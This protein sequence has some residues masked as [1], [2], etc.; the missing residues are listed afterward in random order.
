ME[1]HGHF[2]DPLY[3]AWGEKG[4]QD[5]INRDVENLK[6]TL[7]DRRKE[8]FFGEGIELSP[9]EFAGPKQKQKKKVSETRLKQLSEHTELREK[10][11][12]AIA[13]QLLTDS[14]E[15]EDVDGSDVTEDLLR[16]KLGLP[17]EGS[18]EKIDEW[19]NNE[20]EHFQDDVDVELDNL[21]D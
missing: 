5:Y 6:Q 9:G 2:K 4:I 11:V 16:D 19:V 8:K 17:E 18:D 10:K 12:K 3:Q 7:R 21:R 13:K 14:E 15:D 1:S 20:L